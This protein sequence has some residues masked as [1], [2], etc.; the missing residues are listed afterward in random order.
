MIQKNNGHS[1]ALASN[2]LTLPQ[3]D[4]SAI[5]NWIDYGLWGLLFYDDQSP[6]L[7]LTECLQ[8]LHYRKSLPDEPLFR[9]PSVGL[10]GQ[11]QHEQ[12]AYEV[13]LNFHLRHFLFRDREI[14]AAAAQHSLDVGSQ[15]E[16]FV[17]RTRTW[18]DFDRE[19]LDVAYLRDRFEDVLSVQRALDIL[20]STEIDPF[21]SRRWTSRHLLPLGPDL[22]FADVRERSYAG[23]RRFMRRTGE[24]LYL[25][26]GPRRTRYP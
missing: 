8:I 16:V 11:M 13:P 22:L 18:S 9:P 20:R 15:W 10:D 6:W 3:L 21:S 14:A 4:I 26:L 5:R 1:L 17:K 7:T 23:D 12:I 24:I 25:M 2:S 19:E